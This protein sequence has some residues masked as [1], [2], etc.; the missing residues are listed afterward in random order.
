M[1]DFFDSPIAQ[2][3]DS[4]FFKPQKGDNKLR[5]LTNAKVGWEGWY[6]KKPV[7]F[8]PDYK[9]TPDEFTTLDTDDYNPD[10][11]KWKQFACCL[12]WDYKDS[13]VKVWTFN[14]KSIMDEMLRLAQDAD[15]GPLTNYDVK[16]TREEGDIVRYFMT[17]LPSKELSQ[18]QLDAITKFT[19]KP[20]DIFSDEK[21][22][23]NIET[24]K[25]AVEVGAG[26]K[27]EIKP[28]DIPFN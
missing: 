9:I 5:V 13:A 28:E 2:S 8:L 10:R 12:I 16:L 6:N 27:K 24:F 4:M 19:F 25:A 17:P 23:A 21:N 20:E 18:E 1:N 22:K 14:Q 26:E 11:K 15:W 3:G 7:R